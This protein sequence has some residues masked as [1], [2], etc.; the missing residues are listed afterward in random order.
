MKKYKAYCFDL[1]G[2]VYRGKKGIDSAIRFIHQLEEEQLDYFFV[3]NNSS[4][5]PE[6]LQKVLADIGIDTPANRIYSSALATAKYV[7]QHFK[8]AKIFMIGSDGI[9][10]ALE[11][12]GL[13]LV[14]TDE[15]RPDVVVMGIDRTIDYMKLVKAS[16]ALQTGAK[17]IGTNEDIRFPSELGFIPGN[18]SFVNLVANVAQVEPVFVGKPSP[19]MLE[20]IQQEYGFEKEE[21][22][23]IGDNYDTDILCGIRFGCDTIHVNTGVVKTE[24]VLQKDQKPTYC[25]E[26]L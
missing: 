20:V 2:T 12:E 11:A 13:D 23:M 21:M 3:T 17:L 16:L 22:V 9:R 5:T 10:T 1:D 25:I 26:E 14:D 15:A 4:K 7:V 6:Q 19:V 8:E 24:I 18:G